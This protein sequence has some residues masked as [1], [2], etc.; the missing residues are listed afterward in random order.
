METPAALINFIS[1]A[2]MQAAVRN[3]ILGDVNEATTVSCVTLNSMSYYHGRI[4]SPVDFNVLMD[5]WDI[6]CP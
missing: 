5:F 2:W 6:Y 4:I 3:K 1:K